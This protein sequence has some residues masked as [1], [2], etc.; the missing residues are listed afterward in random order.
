MI[1]LIKNEPLIFSSL[2]LPGIKNIIFDLGGIIINIYYNKTIEAFKQLG[3]ENFDTIYTQIAQTRVFDMLETGK[4]PPL[5]FRMEL[6]KYK[7][8]LSD[9]IIDQAWNAMIG[10]MSVKTFNLLKEV[11]K[12]YRTFLLS[13]TNQIHIDYFNQ[14]LYQKFNFN[15]LDEMF[16]HA[17]FSHEIGERK[18]TAE[19]FK[20]VLKDAR[21]KPEETLFIDDL[22][23][24]IEGAQNVG[25]NT[26]HLTSGPVL[27][28]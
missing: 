4:I 15:P 18:P 16:E 28:Y 7:N 1:N 6:R 13:N 27:E 20:Y 23:A 9:E 24:N 8:H 3:F 14:Y 10:E 11:R 12:N 19:A 26:L 25:L 17:Y 22:I 2:E 5:G 21:I